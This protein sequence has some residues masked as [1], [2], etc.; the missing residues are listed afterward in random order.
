MT[1]DIANANGDLKMTIY[2]A[3]GASEVFQKDY[4]KGSQVV[5]KCYGEK[6]VKIDIEGT[7]IDSWA[8]TITVDNNG[9]QQSMY[10][11][12]CTGDRMMAG[13]VVVDKNQDSSGQ[14]NTYCFNGKTCSIMVAADGCVY[15]RTAAGKSDGGG[16]EAT[17]NYVGGSETFSSTNWAKGAVIVNKCFGSTVTSV[18]VLGASVN[19]R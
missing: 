4:A 6:V 14:A 11:L 19:A 7:T 12:D 10:C 5:K 8:G 16:F 3:S 15:I 1:A 17:V 18:D 13:R 2:T 9:V